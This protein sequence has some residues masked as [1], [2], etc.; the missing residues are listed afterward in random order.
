MYH[1]RVMLNVQAFYF[2]D[3]KSHSRSLD[4]VSAVTKICSCTNVIIWLVAETAAAFVN[5]VAVLILT[6]K[7]SSSEHSS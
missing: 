3:S 7:E 2:V 1:T 6:F 5:R 4:V